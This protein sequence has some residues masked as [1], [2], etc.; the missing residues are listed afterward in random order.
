M[1]F[2]LSFKNFCVS[3]LPIPRP[4]PVMRAIFMIYYCNVIKNERGDISEG[5]PSKEIQRIDRCLPALD[6]VSESVAL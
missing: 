6:R 4:A 1:T 2:Q 5:F 3:V